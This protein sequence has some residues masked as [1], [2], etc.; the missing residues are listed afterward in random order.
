MSASS[1]LT[2]TSSALTAGAATGLGTTAVPAP[3]LDNTGFVMP[4]EP[5]ILNGVL[6]DLNAAF[7]NTLNTDLSTPQGQLAM[8]LTAIVGD[9]YDQFLA[10][11]NGVDPTRATGRMQDA[12]GRL[13]FMERLPA[14]ATVVTCQCTG[15]AGTVIAQGTLV[16]DGAGN[17]YAATAALTLDATGAASGTFSCT[18]T[19]AIA[20][21]PNSITLSQSVSGWAGVSNS[22]AGVTGREAESR[23]AFETRRQTSVALNAIGP[24]DAIAAAVQALEGVTDTYV[25][26][27]STDTPVVVGA[28][29]LAPH[30]VYVCVSGG[31]DTAIATAILSKKPPGCSYTGNTSV[32]V[33]DQS[34]AYTSPPHYTVVF[35]RAT[36]TP[37]FLTVTL[38]LSDTV[39]NTA[40]DQIQAA[41]LATFSGQAALG[42]AR[43]GATVY[44][45]QF[46]A[47]VA[48]LGAW[49]HIVNI[50]LGLSAN[51]TTLTATLGIDQV[52]VL[53]ATA[54]T[55]V[56]A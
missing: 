19:G 23:T 56:F 9:V 18:Q 14:T 26:D 34:T 3:Y 7:G 43:I 51:P 10:I 55:V 21:P 41:I 16:Q 53:S 12:I 28:I 1:T 20:C 38:A 17:S 45:S 49:A 35:Q 33:T 50:T 29:T 8:S 30:S 36:P 5:D 46:Y 15:V 47:C 52:P 27:N 44:A 32:T 48:A 13:Y 2:Q 24:L 4:A 37:L 25:T 54:I 22:A 31:Q 6:A 40:T 42:Q 11:A 39:P